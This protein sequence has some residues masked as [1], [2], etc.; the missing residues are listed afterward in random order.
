[1]DA[2]IRA[3]RKGTQGGHLEGEGHLQNKED[4]G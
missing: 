1:M 3:Q 2:V 4:G